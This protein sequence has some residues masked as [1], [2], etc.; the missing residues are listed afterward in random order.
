MTKKPKKT[1][2]DVAAQFI[3]GNLDNEDTS[4]PSAQPKLPRADSSGLLEKLKKEPQQRVK[5]IRVS[6]DLDPEMHQRLTELANRLGRKKS[7]VLRILIT[8]ALAEIE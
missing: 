3:F 2:D 7:E 6:L 5:P 4:T 8:Q 1:L